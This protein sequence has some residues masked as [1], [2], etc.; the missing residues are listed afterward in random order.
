MYLYAEKY[1]SAW[2]HQDEAVK[3][4]FR[5]VVEATGL[6][7]KDLPQSHGPSGYIKF[8]VAYWRKANAIHRWFVHNV[9]SGE[10][11]CEEHEV[12]RSQLQELVELCKKVKAEP[13]TAST[14]LPTQS[15]FFFGGTGYDSDYIAD[16]DNTI[17]Q[18]EGILANP[19]FNQD[20]SFM[21]RSSW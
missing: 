2:S 7:M 18:I 17:I 20:W 5:K 6:D 11:K 15:G 21:Y 4:A 1:I 8:D 3:A 12:S 19:K 13:S 14:L 10:D 16:L 9:Q